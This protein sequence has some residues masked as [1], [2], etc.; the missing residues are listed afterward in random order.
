M[1]SSSNKLAATTSS[2]SN[3]IGKSRDDS[4]K[5]RKR[6]IP[7]EPKVESPVA[8]TM[9]VQSSSGDASG[10][11]SSRAKKTKKRKSEKIGIKK[12]TIKPQSADEGVLIPDPTMKINKSTG[13]CITDY[14]IGKGENPKEGA[15]IKVVYEGYFPDGTLF[16]SR[17]K[18]S[19]ALVFRRGIGQVIKG[20][21]A[22]VG[23]MRVGGAREI[24]VPPE[25]G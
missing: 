9:V 7:E 13:L 17:L 25:L 11:L 18:H 23:G 5:K 1:S 2:N 6:D 12:W 19:K 22:G 24:V 16:D 14:I 15:K 4:S 21:D 8:S 3:I 20:L 10:E